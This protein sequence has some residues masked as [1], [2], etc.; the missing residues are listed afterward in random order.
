MILATNFQKQN[1]E[2]LIMDGLSVWTV[3]RDGNCLFQSL[4]ILLEDESRY[5]K[6]R[7]KAA[8]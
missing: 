6:L 1:S 8:Q 7:Q 2:K 5:N 4:S 3:T